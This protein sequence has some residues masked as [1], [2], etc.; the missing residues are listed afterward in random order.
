LRQIDQLR[1]TPI[2]TIYDARFVGAVYRSKEQ[3]VIFCDLREG[4]ATFV[5]WWPLRLRVL[6]MGRV[7]D[8]FL[9][10]HPHTMAAVAAWESPDK[11]AKELDALGYRFERHDGDHDP[12][13]VAAA[14][15]IR[16]RS[17]QPPPISRLPSEGPSGATSALKG[18]DLGLSHQND[19]P[20]K[21]LKSAPQA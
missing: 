14:E 5:A 1:L 13:G 4:G 21:R 18:C 2:V 16:V 7:V 20:K 15:S 17:L 10:R 8:A 6:R 11:W 3:P 9:R 19:D 12:L